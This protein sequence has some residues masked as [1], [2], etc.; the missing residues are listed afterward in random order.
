MARARR[1]RSSE[2]VERPADLDAAIPVPADGGGARPR[3]ARGRRVAVRAEVGRLPGSPRERVRRA[4]PVVAER[5]AAAPL[6]PRARAARRA[7]P[8]A[9]LPRRRDRD[10]A[11]RRARLRRDADEAPPRREPRAEA[12]GGDPRDL[13]R[14]RRARLGRRRALAGG[15]RLAAVEAGGAGA[16]LRP[17][18]LHRAIGTRRSSGSM[19][20]RRSVST[21]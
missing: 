12:L 1:S 14:L 16:R 4:A 21:G 19:R 3:A 15:A 8:A 17:V 7:A 6:L 10:R 20:S 5:A 2:P 13:R 9:F 18:P 11:G